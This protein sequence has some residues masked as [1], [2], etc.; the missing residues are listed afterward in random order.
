MGW[1]CS[2]TAGIELRHGKSCAR[3]GVEDPG[4]RNRRSC[5][6]CLRKG[7]A[8]STHKGTSGRW[9]LSL[10]LESGHK[11]FIGRSMVLFQVERTALNNLPQIDTEDFHCS[12]SWKHQSGHPCIQTFVY[13][14]IHSF[15]HSLNKCYW[16]LCCA[17]AVL[18]TGNSVVKREDR[19]FSYTELIVY[20]VYCLIF[21]IRI[22]FNYF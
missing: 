14:P 5:M 18:G 17:T 19:V 10:G 20:G 11:F 22:Y 2:W 12:Q 9:E 1:S 21:I 3:Q 4:R 8:W 7:K 13:L 15:I 6:A 16:V